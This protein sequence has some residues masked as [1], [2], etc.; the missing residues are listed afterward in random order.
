M[1]NVVGNKNL[2]SV[3]E[4][5]RG[6]NISRRKNFKVQDVGKDLESGARDQWFSLGLEKSGRR[7]SRIKR[8][9][10]VQIIL[11]FQKYLPIPV[12]TMEQS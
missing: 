6:L 8:C 9:L 1:T 11:A 3:K 12:R 10:V 5:S 4:K 7:R 2:E